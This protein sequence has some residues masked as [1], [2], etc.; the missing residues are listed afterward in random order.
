MVVGRVIRGQ[1]EI[2]VGL[3][4]FSLGHLGEIRNIEDVEVIG[5]EDVELEPG[6]DLV[7]PG[8]D[9]LGEGLAGPVDEGGA[10]SGPQGGLLGVVDQDLELLN[11]GWDSH[12]ADRFDYSSILRNCLFG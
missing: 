3:G 9:G 7:Q 12:L 6:L 1:G 10:G 11:E 2:S 5:L 8:G 4:G